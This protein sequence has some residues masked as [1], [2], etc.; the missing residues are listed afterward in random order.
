MTLGNADLQERSQ[1]LFSSSPIGMAR[2][3]DVRREFRD[4]LRV[5][6]A[7]LS[8]RRRGKS[9][10]KVSRWKVGCAR[11][12][13]MKTGRLIDEAYVFDLN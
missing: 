1:R 12:R 4:L 2:V 8:I 13:T 7:G 11:K 3:S 6:D 5:C 10:R 9:W